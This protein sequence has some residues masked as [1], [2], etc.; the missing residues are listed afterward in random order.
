[1]DQQEV[2]QIYYG[3]IHSTNY[4]HCECKPDAQSTSATIEN[5]V[6]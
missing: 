1:M 6:K 2:R 3:D 5:K 4:S